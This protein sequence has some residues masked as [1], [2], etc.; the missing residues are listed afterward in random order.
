MLPFT[1]KIDCHQIHREQNTRFQG[2]GGGHRES[3]SQGWHWSGGYVNVQEMD[4]T[5][6]CITTR[7]HLMPLNY[8]IKTG[9]LYVM[10]S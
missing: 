4:G 6:G 7:T 5:D 1:W 2:L 8:T 9:K 10:I 3:L